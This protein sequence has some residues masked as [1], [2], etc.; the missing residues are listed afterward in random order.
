MIPRD[1][2]VNGMPEATLSFTFTGPSRL[3]VGRGAA[4]DGR[5]VGEAR[6]LGRRALLVTGKSLRKSGMLDTLVAN[7]KDGGVRC[8]VHEG[9]PPEPDV[10]DLQAAMTSAENAGADMVI[11]VGGGSVVDVAK[12]AAALAGKGPTAHEYHLGE[13]AVPE[14]GGLPILAVP[15]TAGTGSEATWVGVFVDKERRRKASIRGA[16]MMPTTALLDARLTVT[17]PPT[18]TA[19]S[20]MDA[21]VQAVEA[22]TSQGAN[23]FTDALALEAVRLTGQNLLAAYREPE[24]LAVREAMLLGSYMAGAALNTSRLGL[25]HGLAHPVGAI[26][27]AAHGLICGL[28]MPPVLRFNAEV[29]WE[30][31]ARIAALL[32]LGTPEQLITHTETLLDQMKIPRRLSEIGL[33]EGDIEAVAQEAMTSGS[34]RANPRLVLVDDARAVTES[35]L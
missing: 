30:K 9:V 27:G 6:R 11:A 1:G 19:Y 26:T 8:T 12:G 24:N 32:G 5:L 23:P 31:Y 21:F 3:V 15:T 4:T 35:A 25:V 33:A 16:S 29:S 7:L 18:V 10:A 14:S 17:C 28:L 20:G 2:E 22:Y 34:T 13:A